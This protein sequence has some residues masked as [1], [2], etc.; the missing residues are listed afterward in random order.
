MQFETVKI[1][2]A[3]ALS[4]LPLLLDQAQPWL[5]T[6]AVGLF[7]RGASDDAFTLDAETARSYEIVSTPSRVEANGNI[8]I[9]KS[10]KDNNN[11]PAG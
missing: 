11:V 9:V 5:K 6:G 2:S 7:P 8:F 4:P 1:V 10:L 3:R